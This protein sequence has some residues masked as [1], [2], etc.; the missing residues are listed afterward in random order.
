AVGDA[1]FQKKSL[2]RMSSVAN[3]GRTVIFVSHNTAAIQELCQTA[4]RLDQGAIREIGNASDVVAA[5]AR[6]TCFSDVPEV[7]LAAK[8]RLPDWEVTTLRLD[9]FAFTSPLPL[10][11]GGEVRG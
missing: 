2:G 7:D 3:A 5:Y 10:T 8:Q 4:I 9:R 11:H 6:T 1:Q